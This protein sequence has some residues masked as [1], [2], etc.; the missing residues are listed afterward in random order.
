[1]RQQRH[2]E[3]DRVLGHTHDDAAVGIETHDVR[4]EPPISDSLTM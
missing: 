2:A 4:A 3:F 1:V